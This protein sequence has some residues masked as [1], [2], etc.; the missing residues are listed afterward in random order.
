MSAAI[1]FD[2]TAGS[3]RPLLS[4]HLRPQTMSRL[5]VAAAER[6]SAYPTLHPPILE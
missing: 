2:D 6:V 5:T 4:G 3:S 1:I